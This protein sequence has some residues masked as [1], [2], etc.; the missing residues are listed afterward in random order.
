MFALIKRGLTNWTTLLGRTP[1][2]VAGRVPVDASGVTLAVS[3]TVAVSNMVSQGLTDAQLRAA[4]IAVSTGLTQP[5]TAAQLV[6][7]GLATAAK[8]DTQLIAQG[9]YLITGMTYDAN[10][11]LSQM[12]RIGPG[13]ASQSKNFTRDLAGRVVSISAWQKLVEEQRTN[14]IL[15]SEAFDNAVW[16]PSG[17]SVVANTDAAPDGTITA[18]KIIPSTAAGTFKEVQQ[19]FSVTGGAT[20]TFSK[21][22]KAYG[23]R[24]IQLVGTAGVFGSF[25]LNYDL[26]TGTETFYSAST[27][28]IGGRSITPFGNGWY[29][30]AVTLNALATSATGRVGID[31]IPAFDSARGVSWSGDGTSAVLFWGAQL[32][33]GASATSYIR[34]TT[35]PATR[36]AY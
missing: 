6:T 29:R 8:Q 5:L 14:L 4:S 25:A 15:Q 9:D 3:G 35:A 34:T 21:F 31:V 33:A 24:Y 16:T 7:A 10:G 27:S 18:D 28:V 32:E 23:Y 17:V 19:N 26:L 13:F 2:L 20:Y 1:A 30:V 22:V 36:L 11:D 12:T